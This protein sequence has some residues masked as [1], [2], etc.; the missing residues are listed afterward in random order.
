MRGILE[1]NLDNQEDKKAH[2]RCVKSLDMAIVLFELQSNLKKRCEQICSGLEADSDIHDGV[3]VVF[4]EIGKLIEK[5]NI[6]IN[7]LID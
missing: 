2:L 3:Y 4:Q 7:E 5:Y 6:H 1:F